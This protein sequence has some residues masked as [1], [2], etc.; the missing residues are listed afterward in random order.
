M[1]R[2]L[3]RRRLLA[4][5]GTALAAALA[6]CSG[7]TPFVG[8][9]QESSRSVG[10]EGVSALS[11]VVDV[12]DVS[13]R[14]A[15]RDD[16]RVDVVKQSSSVNADLSKLEFRVERPS[17][18]VRL[19]GEW[20]G[21][22]GLSG[23]PSLD[24]DV[25]VPRSLAVTRVRT[26]VGD[27]DVEDVRG[28]VRARTSTGDVTLRSVSGT[29]RA[30]TSTGD[31]VVGDVDGFDG[32]ESSTGD[33]DVEI[34]SIDGDTTVE[35]STG[36]VSAAIGAGMDADVRASTNTGDVAVGNLALDDASVGE[37]SASGTLGGGGPLLRFETR[38]GDVRLETLE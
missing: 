22:S 10:V 37:T 27:V 16:V 13:V 20:T 36:D 29:A 18:R 19:R 33:V 12:G 34:P 14:S 21:D 23:Q 9:R 32:A 1:E 24:L 28:D 4:G 2:M 35:T 5:T 38:T 30:E 8:K 7:L 26:D 3:S 6:G 17:D 31:V 11:A 15:D 25:V